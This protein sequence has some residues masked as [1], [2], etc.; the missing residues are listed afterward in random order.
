MSQMKL[1]GNGRREGERFFPASSCACSGN[2]FL[3][4]APK[5]EGYC[6]CHVQAVSRHSSTVK[7]QRDCACRRIQSRDQRPLTHGVLRPTDSD[8]GGFG[9]PRGPQSSQACACPPHRIARH[10]LAVMGLGSPRSPRPVPARLKRGLDPPAAAE[11]RGW[12]GVLASWMP[13]GAATPLAAPRLPSPGAPRGRSTSPFQLEPPPCPGHSP[14]RQRPRTHRC[15]APPRP[16]PR[17]RGSSVGGRAWK[18][19]LERSDRPARRRCR[20]AGVAKGLTWRLRGQQLVL[21][22]RCAACN[23]RARGGR[24][25]GAGPALLLQDAGVGSARSPPRRTSTAP[26]PLAAGHGGAGSRNPARGGG[27]APAVQ[28]RAVGWARRVPVCGLSEVWEPSKGEPGVGHRQSE[29]LRAALR[30]DSGTWTESFSVFLSLGAALYL[31]YY[32]ACVLQ[33]P[34][35]VAGPRFLAFLEQ[36]CPVTTETFF[37]TL[38]CF[39]GRLQTIFRVFLQTRPLVSYWSEVLQTPDGG[40]VLLDWAGQHGSSQH[41]EPTT[42][43]IVLLLPGITGS[44]QATY[45]L[46]LVKQALRDGY[47]AVV[48]N[49]RGC[50]GEELLTHRAFCAGNT[51]DL[52]TV[53]NH[54]KH[55]YPK[56][57]LLA[58]GISLGGILVLNHL[59]RTGQAA[60]VLAALT[61]SACWDSFE[62]TCSLETPLNALLFNQHLTAAL[63][64]FVGR[65]RK[66]I[67]KVV[68]VD[69]VL[70]ARTIRQF[71]ERYTAVAFG[72][73][74]CDVYY[75]AASPRTKVDAIRVP[76]LCLN[77]ADDPF[78]PASAFPLQ[79]AQHSPH[80]AL[81]ITAR[82]GHIGFLEGLLP[83][84]HC[85]MSRLLHQYARA[86][87]Q[88]PEELLSLGTCLPSERGKS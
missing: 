42:Q 61:F 1:H 37:P 72:Y 51:E 21:G 83:R 7:T 54:I 6:S 49:N 53:V 16:P 8:R 79:A 22:R 31:G 43:P 9:V 36:H 69:F 14:Q 76:V 80:L 32:W 30:A 5:E 58:V 68:D 24:R 15:P 77:A 60:G 4:R 13:P 70:Q 87:F 28:W 78:S 39:E 86:I 3:A 55:R 29:M 74:D 82:G 65:N 2:E 26:S 20:Q 63:C 17:G 11:P 10:R 71:D 73:Q 75:H 67:E 44:S 84:Q 52:E 18:M 23:R 85:F 88:H 38:W 48:F 12:A 62:T 25:E 33:K 19:W 56:A 66:A 34:R 45:I 59:A 47:R 57:P 50:R 40:Q 35:L 41:P 46:H 81:L 64:Q 27:R